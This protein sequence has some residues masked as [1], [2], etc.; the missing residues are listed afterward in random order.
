[1]Q[2]AATLVGLKHDGF[3]DAG[4][5]RHTKGIGTLVNDVLTQIVKTVDCS[6]QGPDYLGAAVVPA[7]TSAHRAYSPRIALFDTSCRKAFC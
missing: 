2:M 7:S 4:R 1:M 6:Y 3:N 5:K